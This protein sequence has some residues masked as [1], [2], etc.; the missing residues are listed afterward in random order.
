MSLSLIHI[1]MQKNNLAKFALN[2]K[3]GA[4][5]HSPEILMGIGIAG[6]VYKRQAVQ[7]DSYGHRRYD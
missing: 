7:R 6:D 1:L 4:V 3:N 5:K 2:L